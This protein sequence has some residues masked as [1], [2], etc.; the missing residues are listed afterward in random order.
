M[1]KDR[2][3]GRRLHKQLLSI[4]ETALLL[5]VSKDTIYRQIEEGTFP[6]PVYRIGKRMRVPRRAVERLLEGLPPLEPE[7][8]S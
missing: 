4:E 5:E 7:L 3:R 2:Q 1:D 8:S 6:L